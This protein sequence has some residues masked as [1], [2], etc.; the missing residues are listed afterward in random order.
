MCLCFDLVTM[1][2]TFFIYSSKT[3]SDGM[4]QYSFFFYTDT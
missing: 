2:V 4:T 1:L 3:G